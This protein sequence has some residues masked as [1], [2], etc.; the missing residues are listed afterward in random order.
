LDC[1]TFGFLASL[2]DFVGFLLCG[3]ILGELY[4]RSNAVSTTVHSCGLE[5]FAPNKHF[6]VVELERLHS[7]SFISRME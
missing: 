1:A 3:A 4:W 5:F 2:L 6:I 7:Y